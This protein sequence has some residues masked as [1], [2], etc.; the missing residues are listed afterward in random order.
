MN[1]SSSADTTYTFINLSQFSIMYELQIIVLFFSQTLLKKDNSNHFH[2][3]VSYQISRKLELCI[4]II[5]C[6][7]L[8]CQQL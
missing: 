5:K 2:S 3:L 1:Y 4:S 8:I 7:P 6:I